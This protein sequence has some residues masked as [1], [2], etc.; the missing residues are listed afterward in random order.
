MQAAHETVDSTI[1]SLLE[2]HEIPEEHHRKLGVTIKSEVINFLSALPEDQGPADLERVTNEVGGALLAV[3]SKMTKTKLVKGSKDKLQASR[4]GSTKQPKRPGDNK[5]RSMYNR[6][7]T[8]AD[9]RKEA[10]QA[11]ADARR[12]LGG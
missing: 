2:K 7:K 3:V 10:A 12:L 1:D 4:S 9:W 8:D 6:T 5:N 11:R